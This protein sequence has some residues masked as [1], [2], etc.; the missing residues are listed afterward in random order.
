MNT[1]NEPIDPLLLDLPDDLRAADPGEVGT[2]VWL[3]WETELVGSYTGGG[4]AW[5]WKCQVTV[6]DKSQ[7]ALLGEREFR[8]SDPPQTTANS[9]GDYGSKPVGEVV[10]YL[11]KLPRV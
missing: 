4:P 9:G 11:T 5:I 6:I 7:R 1:P 10:N 8:G 2:V 3:R